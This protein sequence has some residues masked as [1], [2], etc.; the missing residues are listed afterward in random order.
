MYEW[1]QTGMPIARALFLNEPA[2]A[3]VYGH[4]DDQCFVGKDLLVVPILG[5]FDSLP[6]PQ[7]P[8]RHI[9]LPA[10]SRWHEFKDDAP[11]GPPL[12]GGKTLSSRR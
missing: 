6:A 12:D 3:T 5:Q 10:G 9:Y 2:D 4:L 1:T 7:Q 11:L 8:R